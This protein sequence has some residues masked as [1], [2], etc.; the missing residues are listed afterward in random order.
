M[1]LNHFHVYLRDLPGAIDWFQ[2]ICDARLVYRGERM[3]SL[4]LGGLQLLL[5]E[6]KEDAKIT[7]GF[8]SEDC[9][10]EF[11][12][13]LGRGADVVEPPT[14]RAWG[15]R[16]AYLRGPGAVTVELEQPLKR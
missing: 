1:Q 13:A 10:A 14:D 9:D 7:I 12:T 4:S 11:K 2:R 3:A 16:A 5:D 8:A 15:V 6:D